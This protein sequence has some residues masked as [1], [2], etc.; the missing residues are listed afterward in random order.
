VVLDPLTKARP[1]A[2]DAIELR[3][4]QGKKETVLGRGTVQTA[5]A[6]KVE[7]D[8]TGNSTVPLSGDAAYLVLSSPPGPDKV[9]P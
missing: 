8:W 7:V 3:R 1:Q 4:I 5:S 9:V 6:Q 2:G